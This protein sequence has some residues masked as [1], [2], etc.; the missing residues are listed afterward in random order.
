MVFAAVGAAG[1]GQPPPTPLIT[2]E[3][4]VVFRS[5]PTTASV[6]SQLAGRTVPLS[7][8]GYA[9]T[10][11][12]QLD[13]TL[14]EALKRW[15]A[16]PGVAQVVPNIWVHKVGFAAAASASASSGSAVAAASGF[17]FDWPDDT[18]VKDGHGWGLERI[19][20]GYAWGASV[21]GRSS[22]ARICV[23]DTGI[24]YNH[25]DFVYGLWGPARIVGGASY[26][27]V[28]NSTRFTDGLDAAMDYDGHGTAVAALVAGLRNRVGT[29]GLMYGGVELL[30]CKFMD[31]GGYGK[32]SDA[33]MCLDW[34]RGQGAQIS[35]NSWGVNVGSTILGTVSDLGSNAAAFDAIRSLLLSWGRDHLFVTAA[36]NERKLLHPQGPLL[37]PYFFL[38]AQLNLDNMLVVAATNEDDEP[39]EEGADL[40]TNQGSDWVHIAAPGV[41]LMSAKIKAPGATKYEW[42]EVTGTSFAA[43]LV[44]GAA[45]LVWGAMTDLGLDPN[46]LTVR[47]KILVGADAVPI[48]S[49]R[50]SDGQSYVAGGRRLNV[51]HALSAVDASR[52]PRLPPDLPPRPPPPAKRPRPPPPRRSPQKSKPPPPPPRKKLPRL[53][54][55]KTAAPPPPACG[56]GQFFDGARCRSCTVFRL[57]CVA[58]SRR[59]CLQL[60]GRLAR[61]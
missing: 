24:D 15:G 35:V 7:T 25:T 50:L 16:T 52:F 38:P 10:V 39:W 12:L 34:C 32:T 5:G 56:A 9:A 14:A 40:G 51:Y 53:G 8:G 46:M 26:L 19:S 20:V 29:V 27:Q 6:S 21:T 55:G 45:G 30:A 47:D 3:V 58:C 43:P 49:A 31:V 59:G 54:Y 13:E 41:D 2:N 22:P 33:Y 28:N 57:D 18:Y 44:A 37:E 4:F 1:Q 42:V 48:L 11:P 36:G 23:V 61:T 60:S 17:R